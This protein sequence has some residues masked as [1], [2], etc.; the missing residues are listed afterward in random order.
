MR[1][2][3]LADSQLD[4]GWLSGPGDHIDYVNR[5]WCRYAGGHE[6]DW[7][8]K[9]WLEVIHP[10]LG[11]KRTGLPLHNEIPAHGTGQACAFGNRGQGAK[12]GR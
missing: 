1:F 9:K 2:R 12:V 8:G 6:F 3:R 10:E 5:Q 7:L 11:D 4:P